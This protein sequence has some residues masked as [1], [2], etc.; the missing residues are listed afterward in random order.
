MAVIEP[1]SQV[2]EP[3][4]RAK[5]QPVAIP[6][7]AESKKVIQDLIDTLHPAHLV[8]IA[9]PQIGQGVRIFVTE[10]RKTDFRDEGA[11]PLRVFI[12]PEILEYSKETDCY[13]EGCGSVCYSGLFGEVERPTSVTVRYYDENEVQHTQTFKGFIARVIQHEFDHI[14]GTVFMDRLTST[15]TLECAMVF[16]KKKAK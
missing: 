14:E 3:V 1:L 4:I 13:S 8:G 12:N 5:A 2:G 10:L 16:K 6:L 9:A 11:D 15:R 7:T